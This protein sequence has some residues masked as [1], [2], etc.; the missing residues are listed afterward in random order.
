M[1]EQGKQDGLRKDVGAED[2]GTV[3]CDERR[4]RALD[5]RVLPDIK[6]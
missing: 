2:V 3:A 1:R 5:I 4:K 6:L